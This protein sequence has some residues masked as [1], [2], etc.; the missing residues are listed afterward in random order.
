MFRD[1]WLEDGDCN[2]CRRKKYCTKDCKKATIRAK[3][4][5]GK[6][7]AKAMINLRREK[8]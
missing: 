3:K 5:L 4:E 7:I 6:D 2:K 1:Q 8:E